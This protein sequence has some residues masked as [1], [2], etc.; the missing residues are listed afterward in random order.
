M[1]VSHGFYCIIEGLSLAS[2]DFI[3]K[4]MLGSEHN[5]N[6]NN[7]FAGRFRVF[8]IELVKN[9]Q[10]KASILAKGAANQFTFQTE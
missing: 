7:P 5:F 1:R 9:R 10:K 2:D 6:K 8:L 4:L 3:H